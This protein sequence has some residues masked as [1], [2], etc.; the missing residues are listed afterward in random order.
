MNDQDGPLLSVRG[1]ARQTV[2][3]DYVILDGA[4]E[5]SQGSKRKA[6]PER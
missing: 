5:S 3:P 6:L 4:I 2:R 1:D